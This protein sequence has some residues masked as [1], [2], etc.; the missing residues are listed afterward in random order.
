MNGKT[1]PKKITI[2][3]DYVKNHIID[4]KYLSTPSFPQYTTCT[5]LYGYFLL[6]NIRKTRPT[7]IKRY[8]YFRPKVNI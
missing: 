5:S 4:G 3:V 2:Q 1:L 6:D 7:L 8:C